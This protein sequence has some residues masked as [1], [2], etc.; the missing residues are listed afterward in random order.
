MPAA[1]RGRF[2]KIGSPHWTSGPLAIVTAAHHAR[3]K[4]AFGTADGKALRAHKKRV[5]LAGGAIVF[6]RLGEAGCFIDG[7]TVVLVEAV[8]GDG[9]RPVPFDPVLRLAPQADIGTR[10]WKEVRRFEP[11]GA[12]ALCDAVAA[13]PRPGLPERKAAI[14]LPLAATEYVIE[15]LR[16]VRAEVQP[17]NGKRAVPITYSFTRL[18]PAS[19]AVSAAPAAKAAPAPTELI[20]TPDVVKRA[21]GL[22]FVANDQTC[23]LIVPRAL[24]PAWGGLDGKNTRD[25]WRACAVKQVGTIDVAGH[26]ALVIG[27]DSGMTFVATDGGGLVVMWVGGDSAA[28]VLA[29]ALSIPDKAW[30]KM[31]ARWK[32]TDGKLA[33][34]GAPT[35][36]RE[37]KRQQRVDIELA[38]GTYTVEWG[39]AR[40]DVRVGKRLED[41][42]VM[43]VR[44]TRR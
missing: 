32:I 2:K 3:W 23:S 12:H 26:P 14:E 22:R 36:G 1:V 28:G 25:Y 9:R 34:I 24:L 6:G 40:P 15:E 30:K 21:R 42:H 43:A 7:D 11:R 37:A 17:I 19:K 38:P 33:L 27:M 10:A 20:A 29:A 5:V 18:R 39:A 44:L 35:V 16:G 13:D 31:P 8:D 41:T 4:T